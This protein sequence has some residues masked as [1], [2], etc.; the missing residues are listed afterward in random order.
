M[1]VK[2]VLLDIDNGKFDIYK[3]I[4]DYCENSL[5]ITQYERN[6]LNN[7][8]L[9]LGVKLIDVED[10]KDYIVSI[11]NENFNDLKF[12][13]DIACFYQETTEED[14][15]EIGI[16]KAGF[17][18]VKIYNSEREIVY[19]S[20]PILVKPSI[21]SIEMYKQM[22]DM[23]LNI[24]K[25]LV[26]QDFSNIYL[27]IDEKNEDL[28][29]IV[30]KFLNDIENLIYNINRNPYM[31][32]IKE[33]A[34]VSYNKIKKISNK[35]IIEKELYPFKNKFMSEVTCESK[36]TYENRMIYFALL[37]IKNLIEV[38]RNININSINKISNDIKITIAQINSMSDTPIARPKMSAS[39]AEER[40]ILNLGS[41]NPRERLHLPIRSQGNS[42]Y[43]KDLKRKLEKLNNASQLLKV[44]QAN[45]TSSNNII[46]KYL[47]LKLFK[48]LK[49]TKKRREKLRAT[50]VFL[51][52]LTYGKLYRKLKNFCGDSNYDLSD[53][54][55][56]QLNIK[57]V[58]D[59]FEIWSFFYM[60]KI[61]IQE[62]GWKVKDNRNIIKNANKYLMKNKTLYRFSVEFT[63]ELRKRN[64][65]V[66]EENR[67]NLRLFY[68]ETIQLESGNLRPDF[69]FIF[70]C[71]N[72]EKRFYLDAKY[73]D[74]LNN[75]KTFTDDIQEVAVDKY[76]KSLINTDYS[77]AGSF[78]VHCNN[79]TKFKYFGGKASKNNSNN[80]LMHRCGSFSLTP[81]NSTYFTTWTSMIM[82]WFYDEYNIC[83]NCG[84]TMPTEEQS[85]T[86]GGKIKYHY[87]C[88]DCGSF[89]VKNHCASCNCNKIIKHDLSQKQYHIQTKEKWM[90]ECPKC[91]ETGLSNNKIIDKQEHVKNKC[92]K[93][94]GTGYIGQYRHIE[95]GICFS[96]N[97]TGYI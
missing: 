59:I 90:L 84:N 20:E 62:Q 11:G 26:M 16:S 70:N 37:N 42:E 10:P 50:Q 7:K 39:N 77:A 96:C 34:K 94:G 18:K 55:E 80:S 19:T 45:W 6:R 97:G 51:H 52:D 40:T 53:L 87:T 33:D 69:T 78:I 68:N 60:V 73:H 65:N 75:T 44:C 82:E 83:W 25:D 4:N 92:Y 3:D 2:L 81:N 93:C 41:N 24:N 61:L 67:V 58:Y 1:E 5:C 8:F 63:H 15:D 27:N 89:W 12:D 36:N 66:L 56:E 57:E 14:D 22:V 91:G 9:H 54:E 30:L 74:Y 43:L 23:L 86:F 72:E 28:S 64:L 38:N 88:Q 29:E 21:I 46:D 85:S 95:G 17:F 32:L 47:K 13:E 79:D 76:Y 35:V 48:E 31:E 71:R 49:M